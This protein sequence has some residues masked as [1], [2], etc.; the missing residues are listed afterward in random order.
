MKTITKKFFK[1]EDGDIELIQTPCPPCPCK[2]CDLNNAGCCGCP[3]GN[4]YN[5]FIK[6][7]E[8]RGIKDLNEKYNRFF[9]VM[10]LISDLEEE[11]DALFS[12]LLKFDLVDPED[13]K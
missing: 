13:Y 3:E 12:E 5:S 7:L 6:E 11:E 9:E 4:K 1:F 8:K 10:S 2:K